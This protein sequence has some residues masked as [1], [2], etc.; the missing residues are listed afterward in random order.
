MNRVVFLAMLALAVP[1]SAADSKLATCN[2]VARLVRTVAEKRDAG[3]P[4]A[5]LR[6]DLANLKLT[7]A[8][9]ENADALITIVYGGRVS[10]DDLAF[11]AF[12]SCWGK[13]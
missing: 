6:A 5:R 8:E 7:D 11:T 13:K 9:N 3:V 12:D 10:P 4:A 1:A 2:S